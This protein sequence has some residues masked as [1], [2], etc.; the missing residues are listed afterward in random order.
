MGHS[1]GGG[2]DVVVALEDERID[3]VLGLDAWVEAIDEEDINK[4]LSMPSLFLRSGAWETGENNANLYNVIQN[5]TSSE[6]Y[7]IDGTTH[8]DFA[9]VYMYSPLTKYINFTGDVDSAYL[10]DILKTTITD[11]FN[12]TLLQDDSSTLTIDDWDEVRRIPVD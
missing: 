8:Y 12:R 11:F 6:L 7:Q 2:G 5:S 9:M 4:G 3:A 10:T 1:T